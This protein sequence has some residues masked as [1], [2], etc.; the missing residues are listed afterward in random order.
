MSVLLYASI[1]EGARDEQ[2]DIRSPFPEATDGPASVILRPVP[3][4]QLGELLNPDRMHRLTAQR[5]KRAEDF[6]ALRA[7]QSTGL[8]TG[9]DAQAA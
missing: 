6:V 9:Y 4:V 2:I 3:L 1:A 7:R 5:Q 8:S